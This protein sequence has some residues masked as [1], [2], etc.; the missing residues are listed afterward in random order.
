LL[1]ADEDLYFWYMPFEE[2]AFGSK[3]ELDEAFLAT[4]ELII[5]HN[6]RIEQKSGVFF[7][8]FR[9]EYESENGWKRIYG[10]SGLRWIRAPKV[11]G[12]R[13]VYQSPPLVGCT[14]IFGRR[15]S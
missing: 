6:T 8:H 10:H 12:H 9:C 7:N 1:F 5:C 14:G 15:N 3:D 4:A 2:A 11:Q 13:Q